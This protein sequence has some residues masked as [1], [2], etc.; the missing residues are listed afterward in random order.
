MI[1]YEMVMNGTSD[2]VHKTG[3]GILVVFDLIGRH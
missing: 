1:E 3:I 2:V